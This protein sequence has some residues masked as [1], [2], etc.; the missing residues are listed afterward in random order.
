[1][2]LESMN[3]ENVHACKRRKYSIILE[4][5]YC[6]TFLY[7]CTCMFIATCMLKNIHHDHQMIL[8]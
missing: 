2:H 5:L 4:L 6:N 1:M 3:E 8:L 7:M